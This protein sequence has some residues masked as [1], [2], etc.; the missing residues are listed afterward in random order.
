MFVGQRIAGLAPAH[1]RV[2]G[3]RPSG[4][5]ILA[6]ALQEIQIERVVVELRPAGVF[7][8]QQPP[9]KIV[10]FLPGQENIL[11]RG[12]HE[13]VA[14]RNH[15]TLHPNAA[16][17]PEHLGQ[18]LHIA[19]PENSGIGADPIPPIQ[20]LLQSRHRLL[21]HPGAGHRFVVLFLHPVQ[22]NHPAQILGRQ[23]LVHH[24][25]QKQPVGAA[26]DEILFRHQPVDDFVD[27]RM[28][29]RFAPGDRHDR[30]PRFLD[31][32]DG[33]IHRHHLI[34]HRLV[35]PDPPAADAGQ[36][37]HLQRLQHR[38]QRK[39]PPPPRLLLKNVTGKAHGQLHR[40]FRPLGNS[41]LP[42]T[43]RSGH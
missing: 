11:I 42:R 6:V 31:R 32:G 29:R 26:I 40:P 8:R 38:N 36:V 43:H 30:R 28:D 25:L 39:P 18:I 10:R 3:V 33:L 13:I 15:R 20:R 22:M 2:R 12:I 5:L 4:A 19:A 34:Q 24:P 37:A 17:Q 41:G 27:T 35:L 14:R 21:K 1:H 7:R 16:N 23:N 9:E